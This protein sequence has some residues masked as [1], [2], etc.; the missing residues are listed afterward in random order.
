MSVETY[1]I[2]IEI[3]GGGLWQVEVKA[4]EVAEGAELAGGVD[5]GFSGAVCEG[6]CAL[7][8]W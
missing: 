4:V 5:E 2:Y 8:C 6:F 3:E 1:S 7:V